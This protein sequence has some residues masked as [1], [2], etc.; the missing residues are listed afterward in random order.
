MGSDYYFDLSPVLGWAV[1]VVAAR[2]YTKDG[3]L[4]SKLTARYNKLLWATISEMPQKYHTVK[5]LALLCTWPMPSTVESSNKNGKEKVEN[6]PGRLGLSEI[7]PTF[8]LS[9]IMVQIAMQTGLHSSLH[10]QDFIQQTRSVTQ[11]EMEDRQLT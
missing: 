1:I 6:G 11:A 5:A 4:L 10:T 2:R 7:D 9:G 8:M 3:Q